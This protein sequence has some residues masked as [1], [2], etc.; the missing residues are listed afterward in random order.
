MRTSSQM[1]MRWYCVVQKCCS[2]S[3]ISNAA[4]FPL[5]FENIHCRFIQ[6]PNCNIGVPRWESRLSLV[7]ASSVLLVSREGR[8]V[9][10]RHDDRAAA[11]VPVCLLHSRRC[12]GPDNASDRHEEAGNTRALVTDRIA[13]EMHWDKATH[14]R[15][16][17][18]MRP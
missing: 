15:M 11:R 4:P 14:T 8:S 18:L 3:A 13:D 5:L 1:K 16:L 7:S 9:G 10:G 2:M 6:Q 12:V 17:P